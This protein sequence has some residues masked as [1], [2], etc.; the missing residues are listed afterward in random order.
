MKEDVKSFVEEIEKNRE[1]FK[2][3]FYLGVMVILFMATL[4]WVGFVTP[5]IQM[6]IWLPLFILLMASIVWFLWMLAV[7]TTEYHE[8]LTE[9]IISFREILRNRMRKALEELNDEKS[10]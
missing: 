2:G 7:V 3:M 8:S 10:N 4:I 9:M 6:V 1:S 5:P